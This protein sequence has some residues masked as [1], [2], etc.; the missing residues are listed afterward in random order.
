M[1]NRSDYWIPLGDALAKIE[2]LDS[3][4]D[5]RSMIANGLCSGLL[6]SRSAGGSARNPASCTETLGRNGEIPTVVWDSIFNPPRTWRTTE[7]NWQAGSC[8]LNCRFDGQLSFIRLHSSDL[9][10][11]VGRAVM[12]N[13]SRYFGHIRASRNIAH[14]PE[15]MTTQT[16][17]LPTSRS[18][19]PQSPQAVQQP[20]ERGRPKGSGGWQNSDAIIV[21]KM[22]KMIQEN[23]DMSVFGAAMHF[24]SEANGNGEPESKQRR[25]AERYRNIYP[26]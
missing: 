21:E 5:A 26:D 25:L 24:A 4:W 6:R 7:L 10:Q 3:E 17:E 15:V 18:A 1:D 20:K 22:R 19:P 8:K 13:A 11:M 23:P 9:E 2:A 16:D 12:M 14:S